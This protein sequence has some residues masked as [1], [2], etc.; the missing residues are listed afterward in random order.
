MHT[1][2]MCQYSDDDGAKLIVL[3]FP[4]SSD[5]R[6]FALRIFHNLEQAT[7]LLEVTTTLYINA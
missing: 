4:H 5:V 6:I 1:L 7:K 3:E 2:N